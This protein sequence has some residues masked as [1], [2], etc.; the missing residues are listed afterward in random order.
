MILGPDDPR[1]ITGKAREAA[2]AYTAAFN[3]HVLGL[4]PLTPAEEARKQKQLDTILK[5]IGWE[6][7]S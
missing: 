2:Q 4:K 6:D 1:A 3:E 7:E 5:A